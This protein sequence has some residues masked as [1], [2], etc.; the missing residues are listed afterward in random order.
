VVVLVVVVDGV[1]EFD[2][3][4][5]RIPP[6]ESR[7]RMLA[8]KTPAAF[9]AFDLLAEGDESLLELPY[10][11]RRARLEA[12]VDGGRVQ[13]TPM[14]DDGTAALLGALSSI[15]GLD[16]V[17]CR[18][19]EREGETYVLFRYGRSNRELST[20]VARLAPTIR[21]AAPGLDFLVYLQFVAGGRELLA[22]IAVPTR[23]AIRLATAVRS[24]GTG[25][26]ASV[27]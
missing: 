15:S 8:E 18:E 24:V 5:Q 9:V 12:V 20:F 16:A 3:L 21:A 19:A 26:G 17:E 13:L 6:A 27:R 25:R 7:V 22:R 11:E 14:T 2:L 23:D 1:Q 4:G 10:E